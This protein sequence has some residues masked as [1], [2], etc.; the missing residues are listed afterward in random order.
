MKKAPASTSPNSY[1]SKANLLPASPAL[2]PR[3][4]RVVAA[5]LLVTAIF[6]ALVIYARVFSDQTAFDRDYIEYWAQGQL[7]AHHADPFDPAAIL[8]VQ[9]T[10]GLQR[11]TALISFSP[12]V[13]LWLTLPLGHVSPRAGLY[14]W[15]LAQFAAL[16]LALWLLWILNGRPLSRW[17]LLG[18]L[19]APVIECQ[20]LGQL[21]IFLLLCLV[22]FLL[23]YKTHAFVAGALLAPFALKPHLLLPF[24]LVLLVWVMLRRTYALLAG[25]AVTLA[26]SC[27]LSL[28]L[29]PQA[30]F[31]Y[32]HMMAGS[33]VMQ[34]FIPA[35]PVVLRFVIDRNAHWIQFAPEIGACAWALWYF[36]TR[37]NRWNWAHNG[38]V[39]LLVAAVCTPY[40]W[41]FDE[42]ILLPAVLAGLYS[43]LENRRSV[44]PLAVIA[45]VSLAE[46][47][48]D[49]PLGYYLWTTPAWL[50]WYLYATHTTK[51]GEAE[52]TASAA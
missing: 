3:H 19:F 52:S 45:A 22:L 4:H 8:R 31:Q 32:R 27:A 12:P 15:R 11:Q 1:G 41:F 44:L 28:Y 14:G 39:V 48:A 43:A 35:L 30:W 13:A 17:H 9:Q 38:F 49:L 46:A 51:S 42:S 16:S 37:R 25:A 29:D 34:K 20:K 50:G 18:Y 26:V 5:C 21:S 47:A 33:G 36:W 23:L 2:R 7:L 40:G 24:A 10:D 6:I